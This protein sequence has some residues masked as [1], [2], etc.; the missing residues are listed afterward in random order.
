MKPIQ[1]LVIAALVISCVA[2]VA[3][4]TI[5]GD[6]KRIDTYA[7]HHN[8]WEFKRTDRTGMKVM[9]CDN[10]TFTEVEVI[11]KQREEEKK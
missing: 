5:R 10:G 4:T 2:V 6:N 3:I 1:S 9:K 11:N 7:V 8:C